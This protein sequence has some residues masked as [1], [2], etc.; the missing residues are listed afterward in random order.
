MGCCERPWKQKRYGLIVA[1]PNKGDFSM[2][3]FG[4][5]RLINKRF[6][7]QNYWKH[8]LTGV[9]RILRMFRSMDTVLFS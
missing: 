6:D 4:V 8:K 3:F 2:F 5:D 9:A 1:F 7:Q